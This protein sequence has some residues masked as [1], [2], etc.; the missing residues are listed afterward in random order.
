MSQLSAFLNSRK[1]AP[2][3]FLAP[4]LALFLLFKV[5]PVF[6]AVT[7]SFEKFEGIDNQTWVGFQNYSTLF[8][9]PRFFSALR[10]TTVYTIGIL[11]VLIPLPLI[12]AVLLDSGRVMKSTVFRVL[13]FLPSLT[14]LVVVGAV[15]RLILGRDGFL[16]GALTTFL[17]IQSLRW[18]EVAELTLPSLVLL[19]VWRW[20]GINIMYFSAGLVNISKELY[21]AASIDGANPLQMFWRITLPLLKP[22]TFFVVILTIIG[23]FQVFVE[24]FVLF[25]NGESPGNSALTIAVLIYR[26]AFLSFQFGPAAAM[27]VVLALVIFALSLIQFRFFGVFNR[28]T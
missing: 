25:T 2:F 15:F 17:G 14:S 24:P 12:L 10:N 28:E 6:Q 20:T 1:V 23:G 7:I 3:V 19:A 11:L 18:L 9:N 5:L 4:F 22:T 21:E 16:N 26:T 27:G 13:L 8:T